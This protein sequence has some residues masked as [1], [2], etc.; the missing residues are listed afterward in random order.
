MNII[1]SEIKYAFIIGTLTIIFVDIS[2]PVIMTRKPVLV[3][4]TDI[5]HDI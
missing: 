4:I 1:A 5:Q 3:N 2:F